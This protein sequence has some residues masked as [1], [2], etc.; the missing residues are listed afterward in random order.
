MGFGAALAGVFSTMINFTWWPTS[1][2]GYL[3]PALASVFVGGTPTWGGI[4]TVVGG[5][6]GAL[7]VSF[8]QTGIVSA[9][10][11]GLL[12][13]VLQRTDHHP[14]APRPSLE[15]DALP[16]TSR[17]CSAPRGDARRAP[18]QSP[19]V[20]AVVSDDGR[21]KRPQ[22]ALPSSRRT[23]REAVG[24]D[25][26]PRAER[27]RLR[28]L[29]S[30]G[31]GSRFACPGRQ[32][33]GRDGASSPPLI[34]AH[35][36]TQTL[37]STDRGFLAGR[38]KIRARSANSKTK[39]LGPRLRGDERMWGC[40]AGG[41]PDSL[42]PPVHPKILIPPRPD[43]AYPRLIPPITGRAHEASSA[44]GGERRLLVRLSQ[45][46]HRDGHIPSAATTSRRL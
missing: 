18:P 8:I 32:R 28:G 31:P 43:R 1:G 9:G 19:P 34:P 39:R 27:A 45:P 14:V 44:W 21:R 10:L 4:G 15:P 26:G 40:R 7:I 6:I 41:L 33:D 3:L 11:D 42:T 13:P 12:R 16:L 46:D 24:A 5:A 23:R 30:R 29:T 25:P 38:E 2:D 22:P 36:G 35:A 37:K 17:T 20:H